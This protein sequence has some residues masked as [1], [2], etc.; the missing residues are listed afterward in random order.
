[1]SGKVVLS[2]E[3]T[4]H[5]TLYLTDLPQACILANTF[6]STFDRV[7]PVKVILLITWMYY[8]LVFGIFLPRDDLFCSL[9]S[10][11]CYSIGVYYALLFKDTQREYIA[12]SNIMCVVPKGK[13]IVERKT[14][15]DSD[16]P[17][18][19]N[20]TKKLSKMVVSSEGTIEDSPAQFHADF[21]NQCK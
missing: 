13:I 20:S 15:F 19:E 21:A 14:L 4:V 5:R 11:T 18:W 7:N 8:N 2:R 12:I 1:M 10:Q 17:D 6:F 3:Q 9:S 16:I